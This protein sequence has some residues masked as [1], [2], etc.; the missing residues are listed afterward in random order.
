MEDY[1]DKEEVLGLPCLHFYHEECITKWLEQK[2][3][4]P[5][6]KAPVLKP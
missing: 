6:C 5:I 1:E 2:N 4:C 3:K